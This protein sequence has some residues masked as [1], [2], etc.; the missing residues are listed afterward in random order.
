MV[1]LTF[2]LDLKM[3]TRIAYSVGGP[4]YQI[5]L[6]IRPTVLR[7]GYGDTSPFRGRVLKLSC[8]RLIAAVV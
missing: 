3:A 6:V 5:A 1:T 7:R 2:A 4:V 8:S